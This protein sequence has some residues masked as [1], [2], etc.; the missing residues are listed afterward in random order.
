MVVVSDG[1]G[2]DGVDDTDTA[3]VVDIESFRV[4]IELAD[5]AGCLSRVR[6]SLIR[7]KK[8]VEVED[9]GDLLVSPC[10]EGSC[11]LSFSMSWT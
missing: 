11:D 3:L 9:E 6:S 8:D 10:G 1:I 2:F 4:A 7:S 5:R